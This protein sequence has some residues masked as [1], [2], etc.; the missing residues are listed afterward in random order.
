M[1]PRIRIGDITSPANP[2]DIIIGMNSTLSEVT[3]IGLPFMKEITVLY[4]IVRGSVLSFGFIPDPRRHVHMIICHDIGK[5]GWVNADQDVRFGMDYLWHTDGE[6]QYSIVQIGT[7]AVGKRDG[8]DEGAIRKA[9]VDSFLSADLYIY[10]ST[11]QRVIED[12]MAQPPMRAFR[13]WHP[14]HGE[15][16]VAA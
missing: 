5:G 12:A 13:V 15:E 6:R 14:I 8:A 11:V 1:I 10:D 7:G 2:A 3:G 16:C 9:M 4:P